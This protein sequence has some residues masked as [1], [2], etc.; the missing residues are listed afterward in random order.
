MQIAIRSEHPP[1]GRARSSAECERQKSKEITRG[2]LPPARA[3]QNRRRKQKPHAVLQRANPWRALGARSPS[4][5]LPASEGKVK[6]DTARVATSP[7]R[8]NDA[9]VS[10]IASRF[11]PNRPHMLASARHVLLPVRSALLPLPS[12]PRQ[13][14]LPLVS[15]SRPACSSLPTRRRA[16]PRIGVLLGGAGRG[17]L[18]R[19]PIIF[20][21]VL[22]FALC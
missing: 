8:P 15:Q 13:L 6:G 11:G 2:R 3:D 9:H 4:T 21:P 19:C 20:A 18:C 16:R 17:M 12:S 7:T 14:P 10:L 5:P 1:G 22:R